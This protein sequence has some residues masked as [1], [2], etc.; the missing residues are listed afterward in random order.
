MIDAYQLLRTAGYTCAPLRAF[1]G[2]ETALILSPD[3]ANVELGIR[4]LEART[5]GLVIVHAAFGSWEELSKGPEARA[6]AVIRVPPGQWMQMYYGYPSRVER[7]DRIEVFIPMPPRPSDEE[8]AAA[9]FNIESENPQYESKTKVPSPPRMAVG[10]R[11]PDLHPPSVPLPT[12][13]RRG[14][15]RIRPGR[16]GA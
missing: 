4:L 5:G 15:N 3:P 10:H 6:E 12:T 11:L 8:L 7:I 14:G 2:H 16:R 13:R 9:L 1:D